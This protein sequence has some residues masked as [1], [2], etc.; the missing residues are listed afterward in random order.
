[1]NPVVIVHLFA[2]CLVMV[3]SAPLIRRQVKMNRWYGIRIP[4]AF[5]SDEQ[6]SAINHHGGRLF[7]GWGVL[8][9]VG[10]IAGAF[11]PRAHWIAYNWSMLVIIMGSLAA[12]MALIY[13]HASRR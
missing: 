2:A 7:F 6:W 9:A 4:A 12:V 11:V 10:A 3:V 5:A 8:L 1:M 13:R